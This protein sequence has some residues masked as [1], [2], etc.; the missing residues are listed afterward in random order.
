MVPF[1]HDAKKDQRYLHNNSDVEGIC[2][3]TIMLR[4][5]LYYKSVIFICI[6]S[7]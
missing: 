5:Y 6:T 1:T 7:Q 2:K 4:I 3:Q